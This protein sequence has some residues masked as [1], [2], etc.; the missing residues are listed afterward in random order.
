VNLLF[1]KYLI[2]NKAE[3]ITQGGMVPVGQPFAE[4]SGLS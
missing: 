4:I 3:V 2:V 1:Y